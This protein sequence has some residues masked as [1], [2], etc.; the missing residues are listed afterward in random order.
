MMLKESPG[1]IA[2]SG[3]PYPQV[4]NL[5]GPESM[6]VSEMICTGSHFFGGGRGGREFEKEYGKAGTVASQT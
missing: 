1:T 2:V 4:A 3:G 5:R 6:T